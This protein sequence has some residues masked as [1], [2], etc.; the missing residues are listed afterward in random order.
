MLVAMTNMSGYRLEFLLPVGRTV[1]TLTVA[2]LVSQIAA[3]FPA[4]RAA[5]TRILEAIQYE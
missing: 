3:F 1:L 2:I 4:L 5:R